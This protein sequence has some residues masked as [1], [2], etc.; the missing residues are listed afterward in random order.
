HSQ[1]NALVHGVW[2]ALAG[3]DTAAATSTTPTMD[4]GT[5]V[6]YADNSSVVE[7]NRQTNIDAGNNKGF[8]SG[9]KVGAH[10]TLSAGHCGRAFPG[11]EGNGLVLAGSSGAP[12][13]Y[14]TYII[15]ETGVVTSAVLSV[16]VHEDFST[17]A[18]GSD[19]AIICSNE[20]PGEEMPVNTEPIE[21]IVNLKTTVYGT[22]LTG[23]D[24]GTGSRPA[25]VEMLVNQVVQDPQECANFARAHGSDPSVF[26]EGTHSTCIGPLT[27]RNEEDANN[28]NNGD[29]GASFVGEIN[30]KK[31]IVAVVSGG[32]QFLNG[33]LVALTAENSDFITE[34]IA[35]CEKLV[36]TPPPHDGFDATVWTQTWTRTVVLGRNEN[37]VPVDVVVK[38][39]R[40]DGITDTLKVPPEKLTLQV[41]QRPVCINSVPPT[42]VAPQ[43]ASVSPGPIEIAQSGGVYTATGEYPYVLFDVARNIGTFV[44]QIDET[45]CKPISPLNPEPVTLGLISNYNPNGAD[46]GTFFT[47]SNQTP[48]GDWKVSGTPEITTP[49]KN[50]GSASIEVYSQLV[51]DQSIY[52]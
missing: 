47:Y 45:K 31:A 48:D 35:T 30:G 23:K 5:P 16:L 49:E 11:D 1:D 41:N 43:Y 8:C 32:D 39:E 38:A 21:K 6:T 46:P 40:T 15:G 50:V 52:Q 2:Q 42:F 29:S 7:L 18:T 26:A 36:G 20:L 28:T 22:G 44:F 37:E 9:M 14:V 19:L 51:L 24:L 4:G 12:E 33:T 27:S 10:A 17:L 25:T 13:N 34:A 3:L